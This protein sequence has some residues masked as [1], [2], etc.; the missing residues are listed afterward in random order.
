MTL[1]SLM[2]LGFAGGD[3]PPAFDQDTIVINPESDTIYVFIGDEMEI[4]YKSPDGVKKQV[5]DWSAWLLDS[6]ISTVTWDS[7]PSLTIANTSNT[8]Q[9]ATC[10]ISGGNLNIEHKIDCKIVTADT[11]ARTE[12][13]TFMLH[14]VKKWA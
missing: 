5:I 11:I 3:S 13:R 14:I 1:A 12:E 7:S 9:T 8:N 6:T 4:R 2:N 10:Y